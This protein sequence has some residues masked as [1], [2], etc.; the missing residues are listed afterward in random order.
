VFATI[1][2]IIEGQHESIVIEAF[3]KGFKDDAVIVSQD[4]ANR[5]TPAYRE[6]A[7]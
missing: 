2:G 6:D 3:Q 5:L 4:S 7:N 1:P